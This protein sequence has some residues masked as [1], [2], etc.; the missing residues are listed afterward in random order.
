[1]LGLLRQPLPLLRHPRLGLQPGFWRHPR[2]GLR[3]GFWHRLGHRLRLRLR[4]R[5]ILREL[6]KRKAWPL[7][8]Q[9]DRQERGRCRGLCRSLLVGGDLLVGGKLLDERSWCVHNLNNVV[10]VVVDVLPPP[11]PPAT[12]ASL[13]IPL[14]LLLVAASTAA[15]LSIPLLL[16]L[17]AAFVAT[18]RALLCTTPLLPRGA[19]PSPPFCTLSCL[20][21]RLAL[22]AI[23]AARADQAIPSTH[24]GVV[25]TPPAAAQPAEDAADADAVSAAG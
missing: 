1:M 14:L 2:L 9:R 4:S 17:V 20:P 24:I 3:P 5:A 11:P 16:L 8:R 10:L 25:T 15:S 22:R 7:L 13:S 21:A 18:I 23:A 19:T 6:V 12:A